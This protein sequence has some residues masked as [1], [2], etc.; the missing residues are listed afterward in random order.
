MLVNYGNATGKEIFEL[1]EEIRQSVNEKFGV[2]LEREVN[3]I[4]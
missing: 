2:N 4:G 3:V 1:S